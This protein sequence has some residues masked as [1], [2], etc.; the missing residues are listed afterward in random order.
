MNAK[1]DIYVLTDYRGV[2][3]CSTKNT[4]ELYS[5]DVSLLAV[6]FQEFGWKPIVTKINKVDFSQD[7]KDRIVLYTSQNDVTHYKSF[8]ED[9]ILGLSLT[10]ARLVPAFPFLRAHNN[11]VFMEILRKISH[12]SELDSLRSHIFGTYEEFLE[13]VSVFP[14]VAK[15]AAGSGS[16]GVMLLKS[17]NDAQKKLRNRLRLPINKKYLFEH[18]KRMLRSRHTPYS[19]YQNKFIVQEYVHDLF[20][21]YKIL[22][23][24]KKAFVL[25]REVRTNDFRAS[26]SGKFSFPRELPAKMLETAEQIA[27]GLNVPYISLDVAE[28]HGLLYIIEMEFLHFGMYTLEASKYFWQKGDTNWFL[29]EG[30]SEN[31]TVLVEAVNFF[32]QKNNWI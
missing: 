31:E 1:Q 27:S 25:R 4:R 30:R 29:V 2:F 17:K 28:H 6:R 10:G 26:G 24:G 20:C 9:I 15:L 18:L 32:A 3:Y 8:I 13:S 16:T 21:D 5:F 14:I 23:F 19:L 11:K 7:W 22:F 12:I